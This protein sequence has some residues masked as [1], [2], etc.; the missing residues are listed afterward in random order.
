MERLAVHVRAGSL[1]ELI[2]KAIESLAESAH[3]DRPPRR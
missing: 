3:F 2:E 1:S